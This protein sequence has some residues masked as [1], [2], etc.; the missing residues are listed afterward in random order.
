MRFATSFAWCAVFAALTLSACKDQNPLLG[1]WA[2][3][4]TPDIK[5]ETFQMA[6]VTGN[7]H[8]KFE[9]DRVVSGNEAIAVSYSVSGNEVTVTY[10]LSGQ[11]NTYEIVDNKAFFLEH[12]TLGKFKY[13]RVH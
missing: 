3:E 13:V 1:E 8:F 11:K 4:R 10:E 5:Y 6:Q 12:P 2:L 7:G 9:P